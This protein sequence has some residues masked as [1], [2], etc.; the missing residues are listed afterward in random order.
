VIAGGGVHTVLELGGVRDVLTKSI[1]TQNPINLV[2]ATMDGLMSM[3]RPA[4]VAALRGLT[5]KQVLGIH[6]EAPAPSTEPSE[7]E[8]PDPVSVA[9][10]PDDHHPPAAEGEQ[11]E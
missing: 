8:A 6:D 3:R 5:I 7:G 1:G 4:Q 11:A 10:D 2:K 9:A